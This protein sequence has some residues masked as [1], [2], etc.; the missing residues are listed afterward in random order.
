MK[1]KRTTTR[2]GIIGLGPKGLYALERLLA[3][4]AQV[5]LPYSVEIHLF[6][7]SNSFG[8]GDI[9]NPAQPK[10]LLMNYVN[11]FINMWTEQSPKAIVSNPRSFVQWLK[12]HAE[13]FPEET[14]YTFSARATVGRYLSEG[15][16]ELLQACPP[17]AKI[18]THV[19]T[20]KS[21]KEKNKHYTLSYE[22][23]YDAREKSLEGFQQVLIASGHPAVNDSQAISK[24]NQVDFIY[25]VTQRLSHIPAGATLAVKGMGLTFIDAVLALTEGRSGTFEYDSNQE[26]I[27][28]KSGQEPATIYPFSK[29]GALMI[30]RGNTYGKPTHTPFYFSEKEVKK[31]PVQDGKY[32]FENQL[33]PLIAQ[34]F[35]AVYYDKVFSQKG[36]QLNLVEDFTKVQAQIDTF[37]VQFPA[38]ERFD[39]QHFLF[40]NPT[41]PNT[42]ERTLKSLEENIKAAELGM[43][44]SPIAATAKLWR[45]LSGLFNEVYQFGGLSP[46][47]QRL[48]LQHYAGHFNRVSYGPPIKNMK[49]IKAL[50]QAGI[51][52]FSYAKNPSFSSTDSITLTYPTTD[53]TVRV[54]YLIDAR[55]PKY[56][57]EHTAD[58]LYKSLLENGLIQPYINTHSTESSFQPGCL[59]IDSNGHP[60]AKD[61]H[62]NEQLTFIGTPTEGLTYD[63][64]TLSRYRNDFVSGWAKNLVQSLATDS[65]TTT[66]NPSYPYA[67]PA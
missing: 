1:N 24:A 34:E 54:D 36:L 11:G 45:E 23:A 39:F 63:N 37:H 22:A 57:L 41:A 27:Y 50:A 26:L 44:H 14:A 29:S 16:Q 42:H 55:I 51:I 28:K 49:K 43:E 61:G 18:I 47:S 35:T 52:D 17:R 40:S 12:A 19:G 60:L 62:A 30:P 15:F 31:L 2:I 9:Y 33:L 59:A 4:L 10:Y 5:D 46:Q 8:A 3:N 6:N 20:V 66:K 38:E 65:S 7:K 13:E 21:L 53:E 58:E 48:F 32:D 64:D 67:K 56:S 25:P